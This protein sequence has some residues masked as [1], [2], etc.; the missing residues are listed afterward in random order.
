MHVYTYI[1]IVIDT[2]IHIFI[3]RVHGKN[4]VII[5]STLHYN[6]QV[7]HKHTY[8]AHKHTYEHTHMNMHKYNT[9]AHSTY[10]NKLALMRSCV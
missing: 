2:N 6:I 4:D 5:T 1:H 10:T 8:K 9:Q 7:Q 3:Y